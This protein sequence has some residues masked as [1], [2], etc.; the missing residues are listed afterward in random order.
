M[1]CLAGTIS[2]AGVAAVQCLGGRHCSRPHHRRENN[3]SEA[4]RCGTARCVRNQCTSRSNCFCMPLIWLVY[5]YV[6]AVKLANMKAFISWHNFRP[7]STVKSHSYPVSLNFRRYVLTVRTRTGSLVL[8][9]SCIFLP[10]SEKITSRYQN[11]TGKHQR[12]SHHSGIVTVTTWLFK[13][14]GQ[15]WLQ[16]QNMY[17]S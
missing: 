9:L 3:F 11:H 1:Y 6:Q 16:H 10:L 8:W 5:E 7:V 15:T 2:V 17:C 14:L 13:E 12:I 4:F